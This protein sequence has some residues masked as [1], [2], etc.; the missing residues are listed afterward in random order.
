MT[1][2][3]MAVLSDLFREKALNQTS[4]DRAALIDLM[5]STFALKNRRSAE[6]W[7]TDA[8]TQRNILNR[9]SDPLGFKMRL[10][11]VESYLRGTPSTT[12]QKFTRLEDWPQ[13]NGDRLRRYLTDDYTRIALTRLVV[14]AEATEFEYDADSSPS[15]EID[16]EEM[17][18]FDDLFD[19]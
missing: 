6:L 2:D 4:A 8:T 16:D 14:T 3:E 10:A 17:D 11:F 18:E 15:V 7:V 13:K 5:T 9:N 19:V 12:P 1:N